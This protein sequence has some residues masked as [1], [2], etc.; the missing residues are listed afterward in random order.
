MRLAL[1]AQAGG[2]AF[3]EGLRRGFPVLPGFEVWEGWGAAPPLTPTDNSEKHG[4][5]DVE[6]FAEFGD[7]GFVQIALLVQDFGD[8][9]F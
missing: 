1:L 4:G 8:D 6:S 9:A 2:T 3:F 5:R 7:V